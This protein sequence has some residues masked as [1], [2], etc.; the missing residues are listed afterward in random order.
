ML[1]VV[2]G[3]FVISNEPISKHITILYYMVTS[4]SVPGGI[5]GQSMWKFIPGRTFGKWNE[6][7]QVTDFGFAGNIV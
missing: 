7:G 4:L 1:T 3:T 5:G 6:E 2:R